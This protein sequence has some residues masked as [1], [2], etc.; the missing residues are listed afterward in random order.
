MKENNFF[1]LLSTCL[2]L[3]SSCGVK[4]FD[5]A[6]SS[7]SVV[8]GPDPL[9]KYAWHLHNTGQYVFASS[10]GI[11]GIDLNLI[12][13]W[14]SG[15]TGRGVLVQVSDDGIQDMHE[16]LRANFSYSMNS[17]NYALPFPYRSTTSRPYSNDDNH[18]TAVAGV[19]AASASNAR[20]SLGVAYGAKLISANMM[21]SATP[22]GP[23]AVIN[24]IILDQANGKYFD[25]SNMSWGTDQNAL[26]PY[27]TIYEDQLNNGVTTG[28]G[29]KGSIYVKAAGNDFEVTCRNSS[30]TCIGNSNFDS[31]NVMPYVLM[32]SAV[33]AKGE[34]ASYSSPGSNLWV[35]GY[36]GELGDD[37]PAIITTDLMSCANGYSFS[38][39]TSNSFEKGTSLENRNCNYTTIFNGTSAAAPTAAGA[40]ALIL[41]ANP[42]LTWRDVK[43]I[44]AK[45]AKVDSY[46][47]TP[48]TP[49]PQG[50]SMPSG[51]AWDQKWITNAAGFRFHNYYGFGRIDVDAAVNMA[52]TYNVNLG[53]FQKTNW[54]NDSGTISVAIPDY[55]AT[56]ASNVL[57]ISQN[58][59]IEAIQI[60]VW[61]THPRIADLAIELTSPSGRKSI[62]VNGENSLQGIANY[63]GEVFLTNAFY[64]ENSAGSWT[65]KIV[66]VKTGNS[67]TLTRW[68]LNLF[69]AP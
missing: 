54:A 14:S 37:T 39:A 30:L 26:Y 43:Y 47:T 15:Y 31:D 65:I 8:H 1:L 34:S 5:S 64:R 20:G 68:S 32:I 45:T 35:S 4:K 60:K 18:G 57:N 33:N 42:N 40:I 36:G 19:I 50:H 29:G 41:Q 49:H 9:A 63:N 58:W 56:G 38:G 6:M 53:P 59:K 27:D 51:Y 13:T 24:A 52:K 23:P 67:G 62:L 28:R 46:Q 69:G 17:R 7:M 12:N 11:A 16:D 10:P 2:L 66:D 22:T 55:S 44:L 61:V 3:T 25:I 21:S 48:P